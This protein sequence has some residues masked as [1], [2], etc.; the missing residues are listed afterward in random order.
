M[1]NPQ[2]WPCIGVAIQ[3]D[4]QNATS[5]LMLNRKRYTTCMTFFERGVLA[6]KMTHTYDIDSKTLL[7]PLTI[8]IKKKAFASTNKT[9]EIKNKR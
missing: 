7:T 8:D 6:F 5:S 2:N 3:N 4:L 9:V 1:V